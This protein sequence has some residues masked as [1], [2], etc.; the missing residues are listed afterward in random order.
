[1]TA[2]QMPVGI[3]YVTDKFASALNTAIAFYIFA[4]KAAVIE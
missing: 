3:S 1:V 2:P 4:G